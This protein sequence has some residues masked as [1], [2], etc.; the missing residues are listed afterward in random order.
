MIMS[1]ENET[2]KGK[3]KGETEMT[4]EKNEAGKDMSYQKITQQDAKH[5]MEQEEDIVILDVRTEEEYEEGHIPKAVLLSN[6]TIGTEQPEELPDLN[7]KILVYCRSGNRSKQAASKL[8]QI[9][10]TDVLEF[11]GILD[12]PYDIVTE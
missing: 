1:V 8:A 4:K 7:Q 5:I 6:E 12:W 3:E 11:G 10:Y 9:G 2:E